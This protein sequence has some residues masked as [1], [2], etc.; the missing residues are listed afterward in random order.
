MP[1]ASLLTRMEVAMCVCVLPCMRSSG[2]GWRGERFCGQHYSL[3]LGGRCALSRSHQLARF[4][5]V[6]LLEQ[7]RWLVPV[8]SA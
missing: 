6:L 7:I 2:V 3:R 4:G 5:R 1:S 8:V